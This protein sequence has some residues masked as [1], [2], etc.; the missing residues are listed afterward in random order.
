[1][2]EYVVSEREKFFVCRCEKLSPVNEGEFV[3]FVVMVGPPGLEPGTF[4]L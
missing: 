4:R 2:S 1:M 3:I